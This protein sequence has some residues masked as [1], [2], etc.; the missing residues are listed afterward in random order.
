M[1]KTWTTPEPPTAAPVS[2]RLRELGPADEAALG[3][4]MWRAFRGTVA[5]DYGSPADAHADAVALFTGHWG[6]LVW[7]AS[8]VGE[9]DSEI[10][11]AAIV[12]RDDA[13][14]GLPLLAFVLTDPG[15]QR[16]GIGQRLIEESIHRLDTLGVKE[17]HLAMTRGNPAIT[18]Y[19]RLGFQV[20]P[21]KPAQ[22]L[23]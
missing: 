5:D 12:V 14:H 18:L 7:P 17:L 4:L 22:P 2:I 9:S 23:P 3:R 6:P 11:S 15:W 21:S 8:L 1:R 13:H 16:R 19:Q 10:V 20:V